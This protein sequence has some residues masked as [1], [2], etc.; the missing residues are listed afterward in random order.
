[1]AGMGYFLQERGWMLGNF[2]M[3]TPALRGL[4]TKKGK[5]VPVFFQS[6]RVADLYT[7]CPFIDMQVKIPR[8]IQIGSSRCPRRK[9][10][11]S[12]SEAWYRILVGGDVSKMPST[13]V[14]SDIS[15]NLDKQP[16]KKYVAIFHGCH[17]NHLV[18]KKNLSKAVLQHMVSAVLE[19][20]A[21]PVL[22][23]DKRD[24]KRYW[25]PIDKS[26]SIDY[27]TKLKLKDSVSIMS[28]CDVFLS[29]DTGLYHVAGAL[30]MKGLV[31][32]T[33]TSFTKNAPTCKLIEH[34]VNPK[35]KAHRFV[36]GIDTFLDNNL[37]G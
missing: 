3:A 17:G 23:G 27:L 21:I 13:Y 11:E 37:G 16:G 20:Q 36:S 25:R 8:L 26:G 2:V 31:M 24:L 28:Q 33:K 30:G 18:E 1:M 12:D 34:I 29:N 14:D 19:R 10:R 6:P 5:K 7:N 4:S 32:W 22:L 9:K 35:A 15:L